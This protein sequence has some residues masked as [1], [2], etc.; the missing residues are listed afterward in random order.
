MLAFLIKVKALL[1]TLLSMLCIIPF[2]CVGAVQLFIEDSYSHEDIYTSIF[3][4]DVTSEVQM[5]N[6]EVSLVGMDDSYWVHFKTNP[7]KIE[8]LFFQN[9]SLYRFTEIEK[10]EWESVNSYSPDWFQSKNISEGGKYY[11]CIDCEGKYFCYLWISSRQEDVYFLK[12]T[13]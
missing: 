11:K 10:S 12:A 1:V 6:A 13:I 2:L 7:N 4:E 9:E 5:V 3:Q 8:E